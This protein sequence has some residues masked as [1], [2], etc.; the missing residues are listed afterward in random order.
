MRSVYIARRQLIILLLDKW[1]H[2][3]LPVVRESCV[4]ITVWIQQKFGRAVQ[5]VGEDWRRVQCT[6]VGKDLKD[7]HTVITASAH[8]TKSLIFRV[9]ISLKASLPP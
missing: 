8:L 3:L 2:L 1:T 5:S 9:S 4:T 7:S 6:T